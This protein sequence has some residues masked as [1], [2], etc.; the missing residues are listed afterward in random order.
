M[1][2]NHNCNNKLKDTCGFGFLLW[3]MKSNFAEHRDQYITKQLSQ[4]LSI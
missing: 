4:N 1:K 2:Q 3:M